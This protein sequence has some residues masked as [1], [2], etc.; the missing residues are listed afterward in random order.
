MT[1]KSG[2]FI[3][4]GDGHLQQQDN[5]FHAGAGRCQSRGQ[6]AYT[7]QGNKAHHEVGGAGTTMGNVESNTFTMDN[8]GMVFAYRK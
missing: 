2:V 6:A 3:I 4:N 1:V 8:E 5:L 7:R